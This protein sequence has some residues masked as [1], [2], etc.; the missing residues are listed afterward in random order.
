MEIAHQEEKPVAG[1]L[2]RI[3]AL[4]VIAGIL[5]GCDTM[6]ALGRDIEKLGGKIERK[7][8]EKKN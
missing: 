5:A 2:Q 4:T 6:A 1:T 7:A 3:L 8:E